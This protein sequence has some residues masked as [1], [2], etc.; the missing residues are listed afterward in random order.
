[1]NYVNKMLNRMKDPVPK[2]DHYAKTDQI[3]N[4]YVQRLFKEFEAKYKERIIAYQFANG[5]KAP[6]PV[7]WD[8][9]AWSWV[10]RRNRRKQV[11]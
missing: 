1:M 8:G 7:H 10:P 4:P 3:D 11:K 2:Q 5:R 9:Y 6:L